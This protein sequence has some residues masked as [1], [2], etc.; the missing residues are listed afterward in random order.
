MNALWIYECDLQ[1]SMAAATHKLL[2]FRRE[3]TRDFIRQNLFTP[4]DG[5]DVRTIIERA[6]DNFKTGVCS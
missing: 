5:R 2:M 1:E 3:V 4:Y 6:L